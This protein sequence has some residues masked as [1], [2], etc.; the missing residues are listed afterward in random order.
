MRKEKLITGVRVTQ[1]KEIAKV[2]YSVERIRRGSED[3]L[4][5]RT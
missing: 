2:M 4:I 5:I 1:Q 3:R